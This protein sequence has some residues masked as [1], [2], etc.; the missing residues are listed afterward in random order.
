MKTSIFVLLTFSFSIIFSSCY[1]QK[2]NGLISRIENNLVEINSID[3]FLIKEHRDTLKRL[4]LIEQMKK[5]N[6]PGIGIVII[7]N[8]KIDKKLYYGTE[9]ANTKKMVNDKTV[10][11]TGSTSKLLASV[12]ILELVEK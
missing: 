8:F 7:D 5:Y 2:D 1:K 3:N 12:L 6:T 9:E 11:Q 10:F 4:N